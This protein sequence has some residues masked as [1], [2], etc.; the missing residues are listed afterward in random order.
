MFPTEPIPTAIAL[1][2]F[3]VLLALAAIFSRTLGRVGVPVVL[4]FMVVGIL[5]GSEGLGRIEFDNYH[6]A[7]RIG[8]VAL[9]L[10]LF[11]GGLNTSTEGLRANIVPSVVL[12]TIGVGMTAGLLALGAHV[13]GLPWREAFLLGAVVSSTDAAAVFSILRGSGLHLKKRVGTTLELESGLND[14]MAVILTLALTRSFFEPGTLGATLILEVLLQLAIGAAGGLIFGHAG[15]QLLRRVQV[16]AGGLFPVLSLAIAFIAF[17]VPT[18]LNGSGFLAVYVAGMVLGNARLP[19]RSGLLRV[20]DFIAWFCQVVMFIVLG[21]LVYPSRLAEVAG[22]GIALAAFLALVARP[23][24]VVLCVLPFRYR[25]KEIV[26]MSWIGLRGAVPIILAAFP[27]LA[28]VDG[29]TRIFDIVFFVVVVSAL[30]QGGSVARVTRWLGLQA[31]APPAPPAVIEI[32]SARILDGEVL[33]FYID[34]NSAVCGATMS[35]IPF[36]P[37]AAAM[38]VVRGQ[39]LIAPRGDTRLELGDHVHVFCRPEDKPFMSLLFGQQ[40]EE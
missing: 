13:L 17:A 6:L 39:E 28:G 15:R 5:A 30:L 8:T 9:A 26:Y 11:D 10:I 35:D 40:Q 32:A 20:H 29:A 18:L 36:P 7:F 3:G 21:L 1:A 22:V 38:L 14:P 27:V 23:I 12:A 31:K 19:S 2:V 33:S 37:R 24:A 34:R 16:F 25:P 4:A